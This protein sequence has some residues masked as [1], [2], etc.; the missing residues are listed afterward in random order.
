MSFTRRN[1]FVNL[2]YTDFISIIRQSLKRRKLKNPRGRFTET[3]TYTSGGLCGLRGAKKA[4]PMANLTIGERAAA[5]FKKFGH[6]RLRGRFFG[7]GRRRKEL[8]KGLV[9]SGLVFRAL[10][11][12]T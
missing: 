1:T 3:L 7:S 6:T 11:Q 8:M 5:K 9:R 4:A 12:E 10:S 2:G